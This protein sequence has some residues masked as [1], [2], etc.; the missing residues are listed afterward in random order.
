MPRKIEHDRDA[1]KIPNTSYRFDRKTYEEFF[2]A[3]FRRRLNALNKIV[4]DS[5]KIIEGGLFYWNNASDFADRMPDPSLA[6]SRRNYWRATRFKSCL[7]EI[8]VNAGHSALLAL[9]LNTRIFYHGIDINW[10]P[11]T[12]PCMKYLS[13][14]FPGRVL[15]TPGDSREVLPQLAMRT[16]NLHYDL[17]HVDGGHTEELCRTDISN[18]LRLSDQQNRPHLLLDDINAAWI[19]DVYCE[20]VSLGRLSTES[21]FSDWEDM[22]RNVLARIMP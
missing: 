9:S 19:Y 2:D 21:Y 22:N 11:Y 4:V 5:G 3:D 16:D 18:C 13:D 6:P 12:A 15:Y 14:E 17:F 20:F 8:G 7:L 1:A 10:H